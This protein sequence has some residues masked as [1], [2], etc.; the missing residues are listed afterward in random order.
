[1]NTHGGDVPTPQLNLLR[2][3]A[4]AFVEAI[5]AGD[6]HVGKILDWLD[7][8]VAELRAAVGEGARLQHQIYD[9]LF[10]LMELAAR[11]EL[12]LDAEWIG[13]RERKR[14]KYLGGGAHPMGT[15]RPTPE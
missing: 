9:V 8:E 15:H 6:E 3:E 11:F 10:L 4:G 1:M 14:R 12:D 13:G 2:D 7:E 5:G